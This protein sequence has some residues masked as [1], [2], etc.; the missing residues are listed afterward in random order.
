MDSSDSPLAI[1][2]KNIPSD[3]ARLAGVLGYLIF[4]LATAWAVFNLPL[5]IIMVSF[6]VFFL[7]MGVFFLLAFLEKQPDEIPVLEKWPSVSVVIPAWN[8]GESLRT[9]LEH[10]TRMNYPGKW[11]ITVVNDGSTDETRDILNEFKGKIKVIHNSTNMGKA[12]SLNKG[13]AST[14]GEFIA[15]IDGDS[16]PNA[17]TLK[18]MIPHFYRDEKIGAVTT[19]VRV[20]NRHKWLARIQEVEYFLE[21]GLKNSALHTLDSLYV[22]PGPFS[23]YRRA[24]FEKAGGYDPHNITEDMEITFHLHQLGY[25]IVLEPHAQVFT[26]V[27]S[28]LKA[29][30]RQRQRWARGGWQTIFKYRKELFS[31]KKFF[32]RVFFPL[33]VV[34]DTGAI[35]FLMLAARMF[36]EYALDMSRTLSS[37]SSIAFETIVLPPLY[38]NSDLFLYAL[39]VGLTILM[40]IMGTRAAGAKMQSLSIGG[41]VLFLSVYW[42][43][44]LSTQVWGLFLAMSGGK[45]KW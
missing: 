31:K 14:K 41:V 28:T 6:S 1:E 19:I 34:L 42:I 38:L 39:I 32:F 36:S 17:D 5:F 3:K 20:H 15:A 2:N 30:F 26:D 12:N 10:V 16:F 27:P 40:A 37:Y 23:M 13:I 33:R 8:R 21:F 22:T 18:K 43:F 7:Y 45:W 24:A 29:L 35:F 9:C 25:R 44:I 4:V 11:D